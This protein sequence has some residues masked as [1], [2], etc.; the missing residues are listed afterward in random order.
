MAVDI[1]KDLNVRYELL[2]RS[3]GEIENKLKLLPEGR[4]NVKEQNGCTYYSLS[5]EGKTIYLS[6]NELETINGLLQ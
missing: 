4:I 6:M 5:K 2:A 1:R 3:I